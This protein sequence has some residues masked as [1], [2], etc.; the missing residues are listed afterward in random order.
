MC[1]DREPWP[2]WEDAFPICAQDHQILILY[3]NGLWSLI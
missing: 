3:G 1:Q 2:D